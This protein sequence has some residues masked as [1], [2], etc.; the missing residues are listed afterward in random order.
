MYKAKKVM[1]LALGLALSLS[2]FTGCGGSSNP[3]SNSSA[4]TAASSTTVASSSVTEAVNTSLEPVE[5]SWYVVGT[6]EKDTALVEDAVAEYLKDSLNCRVKINYLDWGAYEQKMNVMIATGDK[7]DLCFTAN[8]QVNFIQNAGKGAWADITTLV[9]KYAPNVKQ[10]YSKYLDACKVN[11]KLYGIPYNMSGFGAQG[12]MYLRQDLVDKYK[13]DINSLRKYEDLE[14]FFDQILANEKGV[15]PLC[16][17]GGNGT[18]GLFNCWFDQPDVSIP[19]L[20]V[21]FDDQSCT[22]VDTDVQ[23]ESIHDREL[24]RKWNQKGY[25]RKDA[26]SIKDDDPEMMTKKYAGE[27]GG[28]V[29]GW[30]EDYE[31][32]FKF[33]MVAVPLS[34]KPLLN[35]TNITQSCVAV[36]STSKNPE[37]AVMLLEKCNS[38]P[39]LLNLMGFGVE[40]KHYVVVDDKDP[41]IKI[42]KNP[43][44]VTDETNGYRTNM[45]W[46]FGDPWM[47]FSSLPERPALVEA[48]KKATD[49]CLVSPIN[50]FTF[51]NSS[52]KTQIAQLTAIFN[53]YKST[54]NTGN[55]DLAK[56]P[57][58]QERLK[59]AGLEDVQKEMQ[60][61]I[62]EWKAKKK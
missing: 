38:D 12:A 41:V 33:D 36:S 45:E 49:N 48:Q 20:G 24:L 29:P 28:Y 56:F 55:M 13:L 6:P 34:S 26:V 39:K 27:I 37:R 59:K 8:W 16:M 17:A 44:G 52:V 43:D 30:L 11:G 50:G 42:I 3:A 4:G 46:M 2:L 32:K 60:K 54:W 19:S 9:D 57:A 51:D 61:Q 62:N 15:T 5:L 18:V 25:I 14:P 23:P 7:F 53:E 22:V 40:G 21:R 1:S 58:Y 35:T 31:K 10:K 47:L